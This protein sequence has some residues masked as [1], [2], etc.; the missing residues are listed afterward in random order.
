[1]QAKERLDELCATLPTKPLTMPRTRVIWKPPDASCFKINFDGAIFRNENR[2]GIG[3]VIR[4]NV[5]RD[6][7]GSIIASL[8][9]LIAPAFQPTKIE[10]IVAAW[11][12]ELGQEIG[13]SGAI[14]EGDSKL[15]IDSLKAGGHTIASV[16]PLI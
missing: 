4:D 9:K 8:A 5:I 15:I 3:V 14:L 11:A 7:T 10:A 13:I 12:L 16:E 6:H 1:M 2:S